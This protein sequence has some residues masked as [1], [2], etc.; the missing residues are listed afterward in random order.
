MITSA[1][2]SAEHT[3]SNSF[4]LQWDR[5]ELRDEETRTV[6]RLPVSYAFNWISLANTHTCY[7]AIT[8][9]QELWKGEG[10]KLLK[11]WGVFHT[12]NWS[13]ISFS[14]GQEKHVFAVIFIAIC[15]ILMLTIAYVLVGKPRS[16]FVW[17]LLDCSVNPARLFNSMGLEAHKSQTG[18]EVK[19]TVFQGP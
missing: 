1:G 3:I 18:A 2:S 6:N 8:Y 15:T 19:A 10:N 5:G 13:E 16:S 14:K 17:A 4:D 9:L 11:L 12:I 7:W